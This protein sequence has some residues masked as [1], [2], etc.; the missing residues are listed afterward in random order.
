MKGKKI[1]ATLLVVCLISGCSSKVA[2]L[3]ASKE[4]KA[5]EVITEKG[6][7]TVSEKKG[8]TPEEVAKILSEEFADVCFNDGTK[9]FDELYGLNESGEWYY[10]CADV[11]NDGVN[12]IAVW[13]QYAGGFYLLDVKRKE[14]IYSG[15]TWENLL[16]YNGYKGIS[17]H[18]PGGAPTNNQYK[19]ISFDE[20]NET[21]EFYWA[22]YDGDENMVFNDELDEHDL[23]LVNDAEVSYDNWVEQ[24]SQ[25][26]ELVDNYKERIPFSMICDESGYEKVIYQGKEVKLSDL[27]DINRTTY[28]RADVN[29]NGNEEI[30]FSSGDAMY[31]L[32]PES[33]EIVYESEDTGKLVS[34][35]GLIYMGRFTYG[36]GIPYTYVELDEEYKEKN[37]C[38]WSVNW[39]DCY[40]FNG[41]EEEHDKWMHL[42]EYYRQKRRGEVPWRGVTSFKGIFSQENCKE[43]ELQNKIERFE[44][45]TLDEVREYVDSVGYSPEDEFYPDMYEWRILDNGERK[46]FNVSYVFSYS[47]EASW[48][49]L[50]KET[51]N[52]MQ[53]VLE[54]PHNAR[55][56]YHIYD[57]LY[58]HNCGAGGAAYSI[59]DLYVIDDELNNLNMLTDEAELK[60]IYSYRTDFLGFYMTY[61]YEKDFGKECN[62]LDIVKENEGLPD[63]PEYLWFRRLKVSDKL[64]CWFNFKDTE[65]KERFL[66]AFKES[67]ISENVIICNDEEEFAE[68][69]KKLILEEEGVDIDEL[70][71]K[72][73]IIGDKETYIWN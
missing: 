56:R 35:G 41:K 61:D 1:I 49:Y 18:R 17:Y 60:N 50:V 10:A 30:A 69:G 71:S 64:L 25:Y 37:E 65:E 63:G 62:L 59:E 36:N 20:N 70:F 11:N 34:D 12:E 22:W 24:T 21:S 68:K 54:Y 40:F 14:I 8:E 2:E 67:N 42:T 48:A 43:V 45:K 29:G 19:Y 13:P 6:E 32:D 27:L 51:P 28:A 5:D 73:P 16:D 66:K 39:D 33:R 47:G 55:D 58:I 53:V 26:M 52:D 46:L 44:N 72:D 57:G 4:V 9:L 7:V 38:T 31:I 15:C 3:D 23:F